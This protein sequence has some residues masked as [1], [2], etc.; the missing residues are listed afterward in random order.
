MKRIV[1]LF[2]MFTIFLTLF[3]AQFSV[4]TFRDQSGKLI[5]EITI[6]DI[7]V[8][9]RVPGPIA[10]PTRSTVMLTDVPAFDWCYG[11]S[12]TSAAMM[13]GYYDR[14]NYGHIYIG[15]TNGGVVP[16]N[17]SAWGT[18]E[19]SLSATHQNY[20]G[21]ATAGHVNRFWTGYGNSGNDPYG[22]SDPTGTYANCTTDY[23]GTNQDWWNNSDGSTTFYNYPDGT[24]LSDYSTC[25]SG[26]PRK[27]DGM[28]GLKLFFQSRGY[29]VA[30][31]YSQYIYGYNGNTT[32]YTYAQ[33]KTSIDQGIP[34][35]IQLSGHTMLG[36][37]YE[38]TSST[39]YVH[40]TWDYST[41]TMTWGGSYSS[42]THYGVGVLQLSAPPTY[43]ISG[44]ILNGASVAMS[45]VTVTD[46]SGHSGTTNS[47]GLYSVVVPYWWSGT[48][49]PSYTGYT[50]SPAN[51]SYSNIAAASSSQT[52]M[53]INNSYIPS[54]V[55]INKTTSQIK[56]TWDAYGT[57]SYKVYAFDT[58]TST[59]GTDVTSQGTIQTVSGRVTWTATLPTPLKK[60][61]KVTIYTP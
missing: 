24:A 27:R 32:G 41:H 11:C 51:R 43:V 25:E 54:N 14:R 52:Y 60:F 20:D 57:G 36:V 1:L 18:G 9:Q 13:A 46:G 49:T 37:G 47:S 12:A 59:S 4:R 17:N 23:M 58:P 10:V 44:T 21:L 56:I 7:P 26:S 15:P 28:H 38:S 8:S 22:T 2:C 39:I 48:L 53:G 40:D 16:L 6:P 35:L 61:Y 19:C 31:N 30:A 3:A 34:V 42:M 45:G 29:S 5:D 55:V 50:F 33:F